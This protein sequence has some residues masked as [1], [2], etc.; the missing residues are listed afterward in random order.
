MLGRLDISASLHTLIKGALDRTFTSMMLVYS[1]R[2]FYEHM[3]H[4]LIAQ[5]YMGHRWVEPQFSDHYTNW[6]GKGIVHRRLKSW[7]GT[8]ADSDV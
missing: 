4:T 3:W 6:A 1:V 2:T 5:F 7:G 8:G